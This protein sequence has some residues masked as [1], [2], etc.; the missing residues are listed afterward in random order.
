MSPL[1]FELASENVQAS[2]RDERFMLYVLDLVF[3]N[4][5]V[6]FY[7][8]KDGTDENYQVC[9]CSSRC[10]LQTEQLTFHSLENQD[11]FKCST[12]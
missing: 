5:I 4:C 3:S 1:R 7:K 8:R 12:L 11:K 10:H 2:L 6:H 9:L